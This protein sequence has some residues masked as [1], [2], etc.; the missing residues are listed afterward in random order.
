MSLSDTLQTET[1]DPIPRQEKITFC[2]TELDIGGAEK[3]LVRVA[4]GL[5]ERGWDVN[6]VSLRDAGPL[7]RELEKANIPVRA[8]S[9]GGL[10][11]IR[12][13]FRLC[14]VLKTIQPKILVCFL[15]QANIVGRIAARLAGVPTMVSGIRVADR[16][17]GV[18]WTDRLT[19][20]L[21]RKYVAVSRSVADFHKEKCR[22]PVDDMAVIYNG[23]DIPESRPIWSSR[24]DSQF[25]I[26]FVGRLTP[27][28][29][30][31]NLLSAVASFPEDLR[32]R[33][34]IDFLGDGTLRTSLEHHISAADLGD[35]VRLHGQQTNVI[36]WMARADVLVLPSAW[37]G[38]PN[39]VLESMAQGLPVVATAVDG[40]SEIIES[41]NT[42][43]LVPPNDIT[44]LTNTLIMVSDNINLRYTVANR[45]FEAVQQRFHWNSTVQSFDELLSKLLNQ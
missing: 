19:R 5:Y 32:N 7:A 21:T 25:R 23:V 20:Q 11:D 27:Q 35:N 22:I 39:V 36:K 44:A 18:I 10:L 34:F 2:I 30:P 1:N 45:A 3:A 9:C 24:N 38:L 43:W 28:K 29:R 42:G 26:L 16:R 8:L 17:L 15:H 6:V 12:A 33:T 13:L 14:H 31:Q 41:G 40:L 37:E 4:V